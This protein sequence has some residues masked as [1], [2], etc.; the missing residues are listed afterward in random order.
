[1]ILDI[2]FLLSIIIFLRM[3]YNVNIL[4]CI[5]KYLKMLHI[6]T[7]EYFLLY[8]IINLYHTRAYLYVLKLVLIPIPKAISF[9]L[10]KSNY[11]CRRVF[12]FAF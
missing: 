11:K 4:L 7:K 1:M 2:N 9:I 8:V 12:L 5:L 3:S 6:P 10:M